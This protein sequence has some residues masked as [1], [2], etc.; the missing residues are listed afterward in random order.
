LTNA[1]SYIFTDPK[2]KVVGPLRQYVE[3]RQSWWDLPE[4]T[5]VERLVALLE[6]PERI[7][8]V[9]ITM[10]VNSKFTNGSTELRDGDKI[11]LLWPA[12][13]DRGRPLWTSIIPWGHRILRADE[14]GLM[15]RR[16]GVEVSQLLGIASEA[17]GL[18]GERRKH[19][20][21][22]GNYP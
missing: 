13:G 16:A 12:E 2:V 19:A 11:K 21:L 6:L 10:L 9:P 5:T 3:K 22:E 15:Q 17:G 8:K 4:G 7:R 20:R 1:G 14:V 18:K